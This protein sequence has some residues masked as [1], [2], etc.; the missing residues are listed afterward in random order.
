M[1]REV[2]A[3]TA[4]ESK[5]ILV[6]EG[7]TDLTLKGDEIMDAVGKGFPEGI[8][9]FGEEHRVTAEERVKHL[10]RPPATFAR[11]LIDGLWQSKLLVLSIVVLSVYELHR[12]NRV[13]ALLMALGLG[14][15]MVFLICV[16]LPSI[17][18]AK[19]IKAAD[20]HR[21]EE[22]TQ[23][24]STLKAVGRFSV[25][26]VPATELARHRVRAMAAKGKLAEALAEFGACEDQPGCPSWLYKAYVAGIYDLVKQH[27][28]AIE[29]SLKSIE[30][31]PTPTMYADLA[32]RYARY[33]KDP[34]KAREALEESQ[35]S[36]VVEAAVPLRQR[37]LGIILFREGNFSAARSELESCLQM[38]EQ[39][40]HQPYREGT[41]AVTKAYLCL[42]VARQGDLQGAKNYLQ[43]AREYLTA[44]SEDELLRECWL[45]TGLQ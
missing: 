41:I 43:A 18:Y 4:E 25:V 36:P 31:K 1:V 33:K 5:A 7:C 37:C 20:W 6:A 34:V 42:V 10:G 32:N 44:T 39:T 30:D 21:W 11:A 24:V 45:A 3:D 19:L 23:L 12:G 14:L 8:K 26:R 17:Y 27:D 2:P 9:V 15:W 28:K 35:K 13:S 38:L 40:R 29:W 16:S 22:V